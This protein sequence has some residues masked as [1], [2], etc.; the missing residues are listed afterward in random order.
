MNRVNILGEPAASVS[1]GLKQPI[2]AAITNAN[3]CMRWFKRDQPDVDEAIEAISRVMKDG[4][5]ATEIIDRY[6][7]CP[8]L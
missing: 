7:D 4:T 5:R 6:F 2:G 8:G 1:H 3:T